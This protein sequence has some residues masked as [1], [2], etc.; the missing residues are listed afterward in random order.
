MSVRMFIQRR[1]HI[2]NPR[3]FGSH[4]AFSQPAV[5]ALRQS[6]ASGFPAPF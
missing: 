3:W 1:P 2:P 5:P 6:A 4:S